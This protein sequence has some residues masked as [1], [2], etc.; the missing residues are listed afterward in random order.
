MGTPSDPGPGD[1]EPLKAASIGLSTHEDKA[2]TPP[3]A[4]VDTNVAGSTW[5]HLR[6]TEELGR[7]AFGRV[8]RAWDSTLARDVALKIIRLESGDDAALAAVLREGQMLARIRHRHVVTVYG[9]QQIGHEVGVWMELVRGRTLARM[10]REDGPLGPEEAAIVGMTLCD[11]LAAVHSEN[12]LHRDIK[13]QN[14][15]RESGGRI[16]LMD[17]GA[18]LE[19]I[20]RRRRPELVGTPLY[21]SPAVLAGAAWSP[22]A[23]LYSVGVL[24]FYLVSGRFPVEGKSLGEIATAHAL[25][26]Q[27]PLAD[28]RPGL[29]EGFSRVVHRALNHRYKTAGAMMRELS[30]AIP[31]HEAAGLIAD[32]PIELSPVS[33]SAGHT[34]AHLTP[35]QLTPMQV[36]PVPQPGAITARQIGWGLVGVGVVWSLGML[37]SA[38]YNHSL[39]RDPAF[40][41]KE[42]TLL[43]DFV[44]GVRALFPVAL[45]MLMALI[46]MRVI[47]FAWRSA[48][49]EIAP[50]TRIVLAARRRWH[51]AVRRMTSGESAQLAQWLLTAQAVAL[52]ITIWI[53]APFITSFATFL[54]VAPPESLAR[55]SSGTDLQYRWTFSLLLLAMGFGWWSLKTR[56][57]EGDRPDKVTVMAAAGAALLTMV[58]LVAPFRLL[59]QESEIV[60]YNRQR[61]HVLGQS[62]ITLQLFCMT[63]PPR[64]RQVEPS[65]P[66]LERRGDRDAIFQPRSTDVQV[67]RD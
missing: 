46:G 41:F 14:V 19:L 43:N 50:L 5:G 48:V 40:F 30:A 11:A 3:G 10:V 61:C 44:W 64:A 28:V 26:E 47:G 67:P 37:T 34:P 22:S 1:P 12:L 17:F 2:V 65:D 13:A 51:T 53:F 52:G 66:A 63:E 4:I 31:G 25:G 58:L 36:T 38:V 27:T 54:D 33:G 62:G 9:A 42:E 21:M 32:S 20:E 49:R 45:Y 16:V 7:G 39:G 59:Y 23:D 18:G 57:S 29:P 15:M 35:G 24:L 6:L 56:S 55:L 8:F 60:F